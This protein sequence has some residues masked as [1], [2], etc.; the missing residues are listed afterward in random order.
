MRD[1]SSTSNGKF[2][3]VLFVPTFNPVELYLLNPASLTDR[4]EI[5]LDLRTNLARA[6]NL[7]KRE[8]PVDRIKLNKMT[9]I[10]SQ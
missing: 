6:K 2:K 10:I 3:I 1:S 5:S 4:Y 7:I 8:K 9:D